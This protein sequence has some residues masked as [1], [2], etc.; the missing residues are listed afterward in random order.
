MTNTK[1]ITDLMEGPSPTGALVQAFVL[2]ALGDYCRRV[3]ATG[4]Q[5]FDSPLLN[6][7]AW[8]KTAAH[9]REKLDQHFAVHA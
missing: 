7:E 5:P 4:P 3:E 6:G 2:E 8:V 9:V 1:F